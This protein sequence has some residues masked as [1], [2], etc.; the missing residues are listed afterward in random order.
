[1]VLISGSQGERRRRVLASDAEVG[2]LRLNGIDFLEVLDQDAPT[3]ALRQRL[4]DLTFLR[5]DGVL[6]DN[7]E[8]SLAPHDIV[9]EGGTR[10]RGIE[11]AAVEAG[12]DARTLRLT[13]DRAGDFSTYTLR[14]L[15]G[16]DQGS[17]CNLDPVLS[18]IGF[19]FKADCPSEF[20]CE[21]PSP[22]DRAVARAP[23]LDYL[24]KDYESFRALMLDRMAVTM[25]RWTERSPADVGVALVEALAY[26][27]DMASYFQDAVATEAYLG[28]ARKRESVRRHARFLG[29]Y[30]SEGSNARVW[31][32]MDARQNAGGVRSPLIRKGTPVLTRAASTSIAAGFA[33]AIRP[34]PVTFQH[35]LEGGAVVFET[36]DDVMALSVDRNGIRFHPWGMSVAWLPAGATTAYLVDSAAGLDLHR[37]DVLILEERLVRGLTIDDPPDPTHRQ[38]VR[39]SEEPRALVDPLDGTRVLEVHWHDEDALGFELNLTPVNDRP[40]AIARGNVVLAD[41]GR[42]LDFVYASAADAAS[43]ASSLHADLQGT[44]L[45]PPSPGT[46]AYRPLL[47]H[48]PVTYAA[49]FDAQAA[50]QRSAAASLAQ[51]PVQVLPSIVIEA[52]GEVWRPRPDLL[53]SSRYSPEFVVETDNEENGYVRFGDGRFG[54]APPAVTFRGRYRVGSGPEGLIG[55]N[56]IGHLVTADPDVIAAVDNPVPAHGGAAR[57]STL[58]TKINAP[59]AFAT[60]KRAVIAS[61]YAARAG[62]HVAVQH[63]VAERRWTGS[64]HTFFIAIDPASGGDVDEQLEQHLR[65]HVEPYRLAGHDVEIERPQYVPLDIALVVCVSEDHYAPDVERALLDRFSARV[66]PDGTRGFFHHA[67]F[68]FGT[69]IRLSRLVA[70]AMAVP[71]VR[72]IGLTLEGV[73]QSGRFRRLFDQ[74]IDFGHSGVLPI[75]PRE[76]ARLDNDPSLPDY[77]RLQFIMEGGR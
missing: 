41:H 19:T 26:A 57:E 24:A 68:T 75:G 52:D 77:G 39:L 12:P 69:P 21:A 34:D 15:P 70:A 63:A 18:R 2:G 65:D 58:T 30:P 38:A 42:T 10:I 27:A 72:W 33:S 14:V 1:M 59:R 51:D 60:Q 44:G 7:G 53:G 11:V 66:L 4:I 3:E 35:L 54:K 20:D 23:A 28:T 71:G 73:A 62:S 6:D 8:P 56:A 22:P 13:L 16:T 55:A 45:V 64:W 32:A 49:P 5:S 37:G 74:S 50:R 31:I 61:D 9:I 36:L 47:T 67:N 40:G 43:V 48:G 17:F 25:P 76:V 46:G 29:Y